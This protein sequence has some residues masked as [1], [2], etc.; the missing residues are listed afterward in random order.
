[1]TRLLQKFRHSSSLETAV[2]HICAWDMKDV[3][4]QL[5]GQSCCLNP[6]VLVKQ[7]RNNHLDLVQTYKKEEWTLVIAN[8]GAKEPAGYKRLYCDSC[9]TLLIPC[10]I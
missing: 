6:N 5:L 4:T 2:Q 3:I 8:T 9:Q 7:L 10:L 1:M